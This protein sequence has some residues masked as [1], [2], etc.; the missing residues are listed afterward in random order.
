MAKEFYARFEQ[1]T[2]DVI[3]AEADARDLPYAEV[4][5]ELVERGIEGR[6]RDV[7][8]RERVAQIMGRRDG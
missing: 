8:L 1:E 4:I 5:R 3:L 6:L 2:E 7:N